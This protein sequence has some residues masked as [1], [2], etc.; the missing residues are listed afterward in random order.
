MTIDCVDTPDFWVELARNESGKIIL[1]L[2]D[3]QIQ[4]RD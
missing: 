4:R 3:E 1:L 2:G